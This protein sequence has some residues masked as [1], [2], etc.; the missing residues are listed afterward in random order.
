MCG[1]TPLRSNAVRSSSPSA[2]LISFPPN[3][4]VSTGCSTSPSPC[5]CPAGVPSPLAAAEQKMA[6]AP[7]NLAASMA[8]RWL[9]KIDACRRAGEATNADRAAADERM[10]LWERRRSVMPPQLPDAWRS[11][12]RSSNSDANEASGPAGR[13]MTPPFPGQQQALVVRGALPSVL[14]PRQALTIGRAME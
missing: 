13:H 11:Q 7:L 10:A 5:C 8:D 12:P 1:V 14:P 3:T 2:T 6:L 9:P 4:T